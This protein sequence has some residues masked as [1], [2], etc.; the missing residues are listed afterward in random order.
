MLGAIAACAVAGAA[1]AAAASGLTWWTAQFLDPLTGPVTVTAAGGTVVPELVPV[2]LVALA[3][4]GAALATHGVPRRLVGVL[5]VL[6]GVLLAVRCGLSLGTPPASLLTDLPRPAD[7]VGTARLSIVGPLAGVAGGA[8]IAV[9]G[10][11]IAA[12]L[13]ARRM[14]SRYAA[15]GTRRGVAAG[16]RPGDSAAAEQDWWKALDTGADPT[17]ERSGHE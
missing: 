14:S 5:L 15:P 3:G 12:G 1:L 2:A 11:V 8:L 9:A 4:L 13:A 6:G 7:Q 10:A 17:D 16:G